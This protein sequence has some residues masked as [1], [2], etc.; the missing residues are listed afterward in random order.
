ML[1]TGD[2]IILVSLSIEFIVE[3]AFSDYYNI[4]ILKPF[5]VNMV[6]EESMT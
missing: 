3:D 5:L 2:N 1:H 6:F 4:L